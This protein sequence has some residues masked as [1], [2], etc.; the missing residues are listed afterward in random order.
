[1]LCG[2][3]PFIGDGAGAVMAMHISEQPPPLREFEP[4]VPEDLA[5]LVHALLEKNPANRP[6]M[7]HVAQALEQ[8]KAVHSTGLLASGELH[9]LASGGLLSGTYSP[10]TPHPN[11]P[12]RFGANLLAARRRRAWDRSASPAIARACRPRA[13]GRLASARRGS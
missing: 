5:N 13:L 11:T 8:L 1:M 12:H 6:P 3:P 7:Q 2:R 4:A 10:I 9:L